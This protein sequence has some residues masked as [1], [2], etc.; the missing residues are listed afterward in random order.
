MSCLS[1]S[2]VLLYRL[3]PSSYLIYLIL[4]I[5]SL[6]ILSLHILSLHIL[7]L[8]ILS[9]RILSLHILSLRILS[10]RILSLRIHCSVLGRYLSSYNS[11]IV[12]PVAC[13]TS[14]RV[15]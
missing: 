14:G 5:L 8:H 12:V 7:S 2:S 13:L 11:F 15:R 10:L 6:R 3:L 4:S 1:F 9:L